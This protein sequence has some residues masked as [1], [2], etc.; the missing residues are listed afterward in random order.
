MNRDRVWLDASRIPTRAATALGLGCGG[1]SVNGR[2]AARLLEMPADVWHEDN[3]PRCGVDRR[4]ALPAPSGR[5]TPRLVLARLALSGVVRALPASVRWDQHGQ[6]R[7]ARWARFVRPLGLASVGERDGNVVRG[8]RSILC[9]SGALRPGLNPANGT[10]APVSYLSLSLS[11]G[12]AVASS[13]GR[14]CGFKAAKHQEKKLQPG[15]V[16]C[17]SVCSDREVVSWQQFRKSTRPRQRR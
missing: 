6:A 7:Q 4:L 1:V 5:R 17:G 10:S 11:E 2:G 16:P 14:E 9:R 13:R 3:S 12:C 8:G 15:R